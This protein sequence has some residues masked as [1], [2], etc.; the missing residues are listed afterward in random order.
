MTTNKKKFNVLK[1][2][3]ILAEEVE[4]FPC[5]HDKNSRLFQRDVIRNAWAEISEKLVFLEDG[6]CC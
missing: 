1:Q 6:K 4:M 5:L 3:Q 2:D